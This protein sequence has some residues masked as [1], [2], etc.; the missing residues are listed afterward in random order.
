MNRHERMQAMY[1]EGSV[2]WDEAD[3]PPEVM[4]LVN[5]LPAG[6][7]LDLGSGFGR[8]AIYLG[9]AGWQV[10]GVDFVARAVSEAQTRANKAGVGEQVKFH[11]SS[12]TK[13]AFLNGPYDFALDVGCA[14]G[15]TDQELKEYHQE[16]KRLLK[17][18]ATYLFFAHL[19]AADTDP[20]DQKW[21][22]ENILKAIFAD[23]F[24]LKKEE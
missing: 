24:S 13:L 20:E 11:Q 14:H 5:K 4:E 16:L 9:R 22:D 1:E 10:D 18:G 12:V 3:P 6:R 19:N 17:P 15:L 7:A 21:L 2:P 8:A 23:G